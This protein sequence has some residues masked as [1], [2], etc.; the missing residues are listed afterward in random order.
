[1]KSRQSFCPLHSRNEADFFQHT[2]QN[3]A[4]DSHHPCVPSLARLAER[5]FT[6]AVIHL[7]PIIQLVGLKFDKLYLF[8]QLFDCSRMCQVETCRFCLEDHNEVTLAAIDFLG[9]AFQ[10][11]LACS[12]LTSDDFLEVCSPDPSMPR[13]ID[14]QQRTCLASVGDSTQTSPLFPCKL[15]RNFLPS[16]FTTRLK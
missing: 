13:S 6:V 1:M 15:R 5:C 14:N 12:V 10:L 2:H 16:F 8:L 3:E 9:Q 4:R 7:S 11:G